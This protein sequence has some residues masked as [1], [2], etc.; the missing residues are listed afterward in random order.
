MPTFMKYRRK[1]VYPSIVILSCLIVGT[2]FLLGNGVIIGRQENQNDINLELGIWTSDTTFEQTFVASRDNLCRIDFAVDSYHPWDS[3]YLDLR[4]FEV[5]TTENPHHLRYEVIQKNSKQVRYK[6]VN[7][8]F[9]SG[10]M[11]N[12]FSFAPIADSKDKRYLLTIQSPGLKHGGTSILL[13]SP[14]ERYEEGN[15]F[16]NGEK[17][18]GDL[19]FRALYKQPRLELIQQSFARLALQKPFPFSK[20]AA[21]YVVFLVYMVLLAG[22]LWLLTRRG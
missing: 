3:P 1:V 8:W 7:G 13:A 17:Q 5:D 10:H 21:F 14:G 12:S 6:R 2:G 15:L 18:E 16:I 19:A 4:L 9:I 20:P 11:F 22:G